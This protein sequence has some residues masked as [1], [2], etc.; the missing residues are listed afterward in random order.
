MKFFK[1]CI[2]LYLGLA[3]ALST[4][5]SLHRSLI[6]FF[7]CSHWMI[8]TSLSTVL[9][10][11]TGHTKYD[12]NLN[13]FVLINCSTLLIFHTDLSKASRKCSLGMS[14][15]KLVCVEAVKALLLPPLRPRKCPKPSRGNNSEAWN[16][17]CSSRW[18]RPDTND[19]T[20]CP[21]TKVLKTNASNSVILHPIS[22][23]L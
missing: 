14:K 23:K 2:Y 13:K 6:L 10:W 12:T 5:F 3:V 17:V 22:M 20:G 16:I 9:S 8:S 7:S 4:W 21:V 19:H 15:W 1:S 18:A 11:N